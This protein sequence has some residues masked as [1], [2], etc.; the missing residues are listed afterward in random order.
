MA[1]FNE[2]YHYHF[3]KRETRFLFMAPVIF[4]TKSG[5]RATIIPEDGRHQVMH[6]DF[7]CIKMSPD[8]DL[9]NSYIDSPVEKQED[10]RDQIYAEGVIDEDDMKSVLY[11]EDIILGGLD[12]L[13]RSIIRSNHLDPSKEIMVHSCCTP[14]VMGEDVMCV[15]HSESD[16][17]GKEIMYN[18]VGPNESEDK[19][20]SRY[21]HDLGR[22]EDCKKVRNSINLVGYDDTRLLGILESL[23]IK[24][25]LDVLP[26]MPSDWYRGYMSAD[27]Q[28]LFRNQEFDDIYRKLFLKTGLD[29]ILPEPPYGF[30]ATNKWVRAICK[31]LGCSITGSFKQDYSKLKPEYDR[32]RK[33]AG[34]H[35]LGLMLSKFDV[36]RVVDPSKAYR[37]I[38]LVELLLDMGFNVDIA[39]HCM[40]YEYRSLEMKLR[41]VVPGLAIRHVG[42]IKDLDSWL[43]EGFSAIFSDYR[44]DKRVSRYA[45]NRFSLSL[46]FQMGY[47]GAIASLKRLLEICSY[48]FNRRYSEYFKDDARP[49][50]IG[51]VLV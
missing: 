14:L 26:R 51:G 16:R 12:N 23:G 46:P 50:G 28:V 38:P 35:T 20:L 22:I 19:F 10:H 41:S 24:V 32:L 39:V 49:L 45:K 25:N 33:M 29:A 13:K 5:W 43:K 44:F 11:D 9:R 36:E 7:E 2:W 40:A 3:G 18:D 37:S 8:G 6:A 47:T 15:V 34:E 4:R 1:R 31:S 17:I 42:E 30:A 48:S 27:L 21:V